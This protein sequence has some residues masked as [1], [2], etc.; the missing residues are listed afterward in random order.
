MANS[1][2]FFRDTPCPD[3]SILRRVQSW[4]KNS[5]AT[6]TWPREFSLGVETLFWSGIGLIRFLIRGML[7]DSY[8]SLIFRFLDRFWPSL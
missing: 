8:D 2:F 5:T 1:S 3:F 6:P 4:P 7:P